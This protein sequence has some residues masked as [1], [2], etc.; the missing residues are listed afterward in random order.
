[1]SPFVWRL[2]HYSLLLRLRPSTMYI[3]LQCNITCGCKRNVRTMQAT[4]RPHT[5]FH[6]A[7]FASISYCEGINYCKAIGNE[8][9]TILQNTCVHTRVHIKWGL[10]I[11]PV[12]NW[13]TIT[14][15][16]RIM[17]DSKEHCCYSNNHFS[18]DLRKHWFVQ[19]PVQYWHHKILGES[20]WQ[21]CALTNHCL[22]L[23]LTLLDK[24][25]RST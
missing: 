7:P 15:W 21:T 18:L 12:I 13:I 19:N 9:F 14:Y 5:S 2:L 17:L 4:L 11:I 10:S 22:D 6:S 1:M 16:Y 23:S 25:K 3:K 8:C 20:I 24:H